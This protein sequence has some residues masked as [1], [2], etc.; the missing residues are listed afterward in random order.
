LSYNE[1]D[2]DPPNNSEHESETSDTESVVDRWTVEEQS[3]SDGWH[4]NHQNILHHS[5]QQRRINKNAHGGK[6]RAGITRAVVHDTWKIKHSEISSAFLNNLTWTDTI[7]KL[8]SSDYTRFTAQVE[9]GFVHHPMALSMKANAAYNPH[10]DQA[11]NSPE[12]EGY[13]KAMELELETLISKNAWVVVE[14]TPGMK[15]IPSTW[16]FNC[17]RFLNGLVRKLKS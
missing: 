7:K 3:L 2:F 4:H 14:R 5:Q 6:G 11:M 12:A 17:K 16:A 9:D 15:V 1:G 8:A 10:W 13:W